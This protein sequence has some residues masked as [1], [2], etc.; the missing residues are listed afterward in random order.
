MG[1][2]TEAKGTADFMQAISAA[3]QL[4][5]VP[6]VQLSPAAAIIRTKLTHG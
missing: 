1:N 3:G 4:G 5:Q 6:T 2:I